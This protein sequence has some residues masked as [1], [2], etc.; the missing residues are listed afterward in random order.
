MNPLNAYQKLKERRNWWEATADHSAEDATLDPQSNFNFR[1]A[2]RK[3]AALTRNER[4]IALGSFGRCERCGATID[5]SRLEQI[6]DSERHYCTD[7]ASRPIDTHSAHKPM[8]TL[9]GRRAATLGTSQM[10]G[11]GVP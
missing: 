11:G 5:D 8:Y 2:T 6:L 1:L 3:L 4:R 10:A 9:N 7:C